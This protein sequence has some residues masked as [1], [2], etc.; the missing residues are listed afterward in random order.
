GGVIGGEVGA[1][2]LTA[3][4]IPG[5]S[6]PSARGYEIAF[7]IAAV[8]A[9]IGVVVAL[10]VTPTRATRVAVAVET[11]D[12]RARSG[13]LPLPGGFTSPKRRS[14]PRQTPPLGGGG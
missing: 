8:A 14:G 12:R 13:K 2:I 4:L 5:T 9:F 3:H 10:L 11:P 6:V 7:G 1:A